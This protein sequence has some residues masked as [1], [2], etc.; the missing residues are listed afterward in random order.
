MEPQLCFDLHIYSITILYCAGDITL[1][2]LLSNKLKLKYYYILLRRSS[3]TLFVKYIRR[4][5]R[6]F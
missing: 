1:Q 4:N 6:T 3:I 2:I 5:H